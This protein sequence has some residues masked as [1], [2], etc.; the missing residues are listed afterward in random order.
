MLHQFTHSSI[1]TASLF[2][3]KV[4]H[5]G[6]IAILVTCLELFGPF[7]LVILMGRFLIELVA[8][9]RW[10]QGRDNGSRSQGSLHDNALTTSHQTVVLRTTLCQN[11]LGR[12]QSESKRKGPNEAVHTVTNTTA[13]NTKIQATTIV[14]KMGSLFEYASSVSR[15]GY[16]RKV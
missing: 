9:M 8:N 14:Y 5:L 3:Q 2:F 16:T 12:E 13:E 11:D 4:G 6:T 15:E 7:C 1:F 10:K